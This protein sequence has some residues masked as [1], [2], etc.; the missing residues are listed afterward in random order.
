ML[1]FMDTEYSSLIDFKAPADA[2]HQPR[3]ASLAMVIC[4]DDG[5]IT[6]KSHML[7]KPDG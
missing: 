4:E 7:V 5:A 3:L 6:G 1:L 2:P